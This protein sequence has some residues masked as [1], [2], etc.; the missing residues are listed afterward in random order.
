MKVQYIADSFVLFVVSN[1]S[2]GL[3]AI[4]FLSLVLASRCIPH[5]IRQTEGTQCQHT[6]FPTFHGVLEALSTEWRNSTPKRRNGNINFNK[7]FISSSG[8]RSHNQSILHS[9]FVPKRQDLQKYVNVIHM[10]KEK[11]F[12]FYIGIWN[13]IKTNYNYFELFYKSGV[14]FDVLVAL[15]G[16]TGT[17]PKQLL[18]I[19]FNFSVVLFKKNILHT[20]YLLK[21]LPTFLNVLRYTI[22]ASRFI[23]S[24]IVR[25]SG[26]PNATVSLRL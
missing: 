1:N 8:D 13:L 24:G 10:G 16:R 14:S 2:S 5:T 12:S 17:D 4:F 11:Y 18:W 15:S 26:A 3:V 9:H 7:Y 21:N 22:L 19:G 20:F 6:P 25:E 23:P